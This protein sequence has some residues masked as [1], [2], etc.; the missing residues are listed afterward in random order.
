M[1]SSRVI[2]GRWLSCCWFLCCMVQPP[3]VLRRISVRILGY[4][5]RPV[6]RLFCLPAFLKLPELLGIILFFGFH[7]LFRLCPFYFFGFP[8]VFFLCRGFFRFP[9]ESHNAAVF[10]VDKKLM[11]KELR[12]SPLMPM[13]A[14]RAAG[15]TVRQATTILVVSVAGIWNTGKP[16]SS[17]RI[18]ASAAFLSLMVPPNTVPVSMKFGGMMYMSFSSC[19]MDILRCTSYIHGYGG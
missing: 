11:T 19:R 9:L 18:S 4:A 1:E 10:Q 12:L 3:F 17:E 6:C 15:S 16:M 14:N 2:S 13:M 8:G 7:L 5:C